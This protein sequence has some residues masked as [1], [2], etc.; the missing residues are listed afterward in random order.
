MREGKKAERYRDVL[1]RVRETAISA[2]LGQYFL[3]RKS[4]EAMIS[5][6]II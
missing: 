5:E 2:P 6:C 1:V 4:N 3:Y